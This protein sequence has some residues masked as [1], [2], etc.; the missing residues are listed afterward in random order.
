MI[1][2]VSAERWLLEG[3]LGSST[4]SSACRR[5]SS[6][7]AFKQVGSFYRPVAY[8]TSTQPEKNRV[9]SKRDKGAGC[10]S[11]VRAFARGAMGHQIDLFLVP[12]SAPQLV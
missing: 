7:L 3:L 9:A 6:S 8:Q 10:S 2:S 5:T 1:S 12:A 11:V 4:G